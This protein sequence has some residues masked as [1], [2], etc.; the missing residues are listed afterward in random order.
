[1][2]RCYGSVNDAGP[3]YR[4][5]GIPCCVGELVKL[6]RA[7][8]PT[9]VE[10]HHR[11]G[12]VHPEQSEEYVIPS[13]YLACASTTR[14]ITRESEAKSSLIWHTRHPRTKPSTSVTLAH[15][16]SV[17]GCKPPKDVRPDPRASQLRVNRLRRLKSG[18]M[19]LSQLCE[20]SIQCG[21]GTS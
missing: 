3:P 9:E 1:M 2:L 18:D 17:A 20:D 4:W 6:Q 15:R 7:C 21:A 12:V 14:T 8:E 19:S 11:Y 10:D 5:V 16:L 13:G